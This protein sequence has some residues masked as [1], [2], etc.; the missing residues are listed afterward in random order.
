[1]AFPIAFTPSFYSKTAHGMQQTIKNRIIISRLVFGYISIGLIT[2][3]AAWFTINRIENEVSAAP[4]IYDQA[5]FNLRKIESL[6]NDAAQELFAYLLNGVEE[7]LTDYRKV[8]ET[9]PSNF[10]MFASSA[11]LSALG[12]ESQLAQFLALERTWGSFTS[13]AD[14]MIGEYQR[15]GAVSL[16]NF[17]AAEESLDQYQSLLNVL[18]E[19]EYVKAQNARLQLNIIV[20]NARL[21]WLI[22]ACVGLAALTL[23]A[24]FVTRILHS[25]V[26]RLQELHEDLRLGGVALNSAEVNTERIAL[27]FS[28]FIDTVPAAT[29]GI[30]AD[31]LINEWN[32]TAAKITGFKKEDVLGKDLVQ[33][34]IAEAYRAPVKAV[35]EDLL[36]GI[37]T[38]N[39]EFPLYTKE[40]ARIDILLNATSRRDADGKI[41]GVI[42]VG[43]DITDA[44]IAQLESERIA[45]E[46]TQFID[47]A[48]APIF[49]IDADGLINEWNQTAAKITGFKKEDV[50]GQDLVRDF[51]TEEYRASVK[52]VLENALQGIESSNY[53]FPMYTKGGTRIDILLNATSRR[54]ADG[55]IIGVIGVG[56]D[57][58]ETKTAQAALQQAQKMEV[59]GQLTGGVAH[60]FNNLL[61]VISGNLAFLKDEFGVTSADMAEIIDDAQSAAN[62]GAELTHR[63]LAFARQQVLEPKETS[64]NDLIIDTSRL[65][66]RALGEDITITTALDSKNPIV[67]V[68]QGQLESALMNLCINARDAMQSGGSLTI[69]SETKSV[70]QDSEEEVNDLAV[71]KYAVITVEDSGHGMSE[72]EITQVFEPFYTTKELGKGSGLG[73]SMVHGFVTQSKGRVVIES[74]LGTGSKV[75]LYLPEVAG[76]YNT[77]PPPVKTTLSIDLPT[78]TEKILVV[79]DEPRVRKTAVRVLRKLGYEVIE[80]NC[81]QDALDSMKKN[82]DVDLMFT[83][84]MMPGGMTGRQL[85]SIVNR[86]YPKIQIQLTT[87]Y[88]NVDATKNIADTEFP[89]LKKPYDQRALATALRKLLDG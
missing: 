80:A 15:N 6:S 85:A 56:Q 78:G 60:D 3:L 8:V 53:E 71:G 40:G 28:Q 37:D 51:I 33:D 36:R 27:E 39:Y 19:D 41:I 72:K 65:M 25:F 13:N 22:A 86:E 47:T 69:T 55:K 4:I 63:L 26:T 34:F 89:V 88:D 62:E 82:K 5:L 17:M 58:T 23:I 24:I 52:A 54:D 20:R 10:N 45:A 81:G 38:W 75:K 68:D 73:L 76:D 42:G 64:V 61:T 29:I 21:L 77:L 48:N 57:I 66:G 46:L 11:K 2:V 83:D 84:I 30:D 35:L 32:Q 1:M 7:E 87:G 50:L 49:G 14:V 74:E 18:I 70:N 67:M 59:V 12:A 79:D 31:G 44:K 43:Q 16:V 9:L